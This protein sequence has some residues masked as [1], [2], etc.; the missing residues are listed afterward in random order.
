MA[1][2]IE[3]LRAFVYVAQSGTIAEAAARLGR[4]Q[5][6]VSM[7]L[8]QLED[9]LGQKLFR[10]ERKNRLTAL[11]EQVFSLAQRQVQNFDTTLREI[12]ASVSAPK[13]LLRIAAVPSVAAFLLPRAVSRMAA[14]HPGLK[15]DLRDSDSAQVIEALVRGQADLGI[16][17]VRPRLNDIRTEPLF[18]DRFGLICGPEHPLARGKGPVTLDRIASAGFIG[19]NL[20]RQLE[21]PAIGAMLASTAIHAHNTVALLG[22]LR[23]G[24]YCTI[25]PQRVAQD[26]GQ[27]LVFRK[28]RGLDAVRVVS[29]L[30][31][32]RSTQQSLATEFATLLREEA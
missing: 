19:N 17:S 5:S 31:A 7:T 13:G 20:C 9:E 24:R 3:M 28:I 2:R 15:I 29:T 25:L 4:T 6:A 16:A 10:G 21:G 23:S 14:L 1:I 30:I 12:R 8:K 18:R 27:G 11:G 32:T 26:L 22:L